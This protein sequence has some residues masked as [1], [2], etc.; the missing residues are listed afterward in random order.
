MGTEVKDQYLATEGGYYTGKLVDG[1]P[2]GYG[3]IE[4]KIEEQSMTKKNPK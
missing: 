2:E 1:K 4:W 3:V